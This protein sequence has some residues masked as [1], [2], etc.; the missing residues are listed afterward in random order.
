MRRSVSSRDGLNRSIN[1]WHTWEVCWSDANQLEKKG[2]G[3]YSQNIIQVAS[4]LT[5]DIMFYMT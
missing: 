1:K 5:R 3:G 2:I 4:L